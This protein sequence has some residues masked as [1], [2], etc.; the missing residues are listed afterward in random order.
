MLSWCWFQ[1]T[2]KCWFLGF[3]FT[4]LVT[5]IL[6]C[7]NFGIRV[8]DPLSKK[9]LHRHLLPLQ[10][11][12]HPSKNHPS[13]SPKKKAQSISSPKPTCEAHYISL[14]RWNTVQIYGQFQWHLHS[15]FSGSI[16]NFLL[17]FVLLVHNGG[18]PTTYF[19][20]I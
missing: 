20:W 5:F 18:S 15:A 16:I 10:D 17:R 8:E 4:F 2:P 11:K 14:K 19:L 7:I 9:K 12:T 13:P 1:A 6:S 3:I